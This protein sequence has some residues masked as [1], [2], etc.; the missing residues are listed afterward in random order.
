M[1]EPA[2]AR[3]P[4]ER[5]HLAAARDAST[6][7][8][9]LTEDAISA[10]ANGRAIRI[11]DRCSGSCEARVD[12]RTGSGATLQ[13]GRG[14]DDPP[15]RDGESRGFC[16][17]HDWLHDAGTAPSSHDALMHTASTIQ[18]A[19]LIF[20]ASVGAAPLATLS[21]R[22]CSA[23]MCGIR[24]DTAFSPS[25]RLKVPPKRVARRMHGA[26]DRAVLHV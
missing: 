14:G 6:G 19:S 9:R 26:S 23:V 2:Y 24:H 11:A 4:L 7:R 22:T 10:A 21:L 16:N 20:V 15:S 17:D 1:Y 12:R 5:P 3:R 18:N 25:P 13:S 8:T